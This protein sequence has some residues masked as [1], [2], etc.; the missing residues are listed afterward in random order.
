V[1]V[2]VRTPLKNPS[3]IPPDHTVR[4]LGSNSTTVAGNAR[5]GLASFT[6]DS[7]SPGATRPSSLTRPESQLVWPG[8]SVRMLQIFSGVASMVSVAS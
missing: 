4:R 8:A 5:P 2:K 3:G 7:F 6:I 1:R